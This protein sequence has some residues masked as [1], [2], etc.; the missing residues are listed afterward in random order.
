MPLNITV[1]PHP[2]R[3]K[4]PQ[5]PPPFTPAAID[6]PMQPI[7]ITEG[8]SKVMVVTGIGEWRQYW[9]QCPG[10]LNCHGVTIA[11]PNAK[12][13]FNGSLDRPT[14]APSLLCNKDDPANR[15]HL[16]LRDGKIEY[17]A[18]CHHAL[19]GK[20]VECPDWGE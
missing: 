8:K 3:T 10:C 14:F 9:F 15:C 12:W 16:F 18:D 2:V 20:T 11:P 5:E 19:A 1:S 13:T 4:P 6:P 17:L 7:P